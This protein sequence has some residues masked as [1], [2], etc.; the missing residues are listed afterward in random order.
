M[1][2][3]RMALLEPIEK[4]ADAVLARER[5]AFAA[6]R[7]MT[8]AVDEHTGAPAGV[9]SVERVNHSNGYRERGWETRA[10]RIDLAIRKL[11]PWRPA[12]SPPSAIG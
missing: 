7:M 9:P 11:R 10:G 8:F 1:T 3:E 6:E 2:D 5:L 12:G 4:G